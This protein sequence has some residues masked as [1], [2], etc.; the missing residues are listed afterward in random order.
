VAAPFPEKAT[1]GDPEGLQTVIQKLNRDVLERGSSADSLSARDSTA[2]SPAVRDSAAREKRTTGHRARP[3]PQVPAEVK[4]GSLRRSQWAIG[5]G[6]PGTG[7]GVPRVRRPGGPEDGSRRRGSRMILVLSGA[8]VVVGVLSLMVSSLMSGQNP[9]AKSAPLL[10]TA[11]SPL[12]ASSFSPLS[13]VVTGGPSSG[14]SPRAG[15]AS[16]S[17]AGRTSGADTPAEPP[18]VNVVITDTDDGL[19][20]DVDNSKTAAGT[21]VGTW[22]SD[23]T[24]AQRWHLVRQPGGRYVVY[25][26]LTDLHE[27]L[28]ISTDPEKFN[29]NRVTTLQP[30]EDDPRMRWT[31]RYLGSGR[32]ELVNQEDGQC[33]TGSGQGLAVATA[34]CDSADAHQAWSFG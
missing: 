13:V 7:P 18:V 6:E 10:A 8:V 24:T 14:V 19:V 32:Y 12:V 33:L 27:G 34:A 22:P 29:G 30:Y 31:A 5:P 3:R 15:S 16:A 1:S 25:S 4:R 21:L 20:L 26:E 28:E 9:P 11:R 2:V 17:P 23:D